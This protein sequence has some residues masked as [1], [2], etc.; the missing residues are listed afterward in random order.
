MRIL[1]P[2]HQEVVPNSPVLKSGRACNQQNVE[3]QNDAIG[4]GSLGYKTIKL[5][6]CE[7]ELPLKKS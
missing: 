7:P 3:E 1:L 2:S 6:P 4:L 5:L